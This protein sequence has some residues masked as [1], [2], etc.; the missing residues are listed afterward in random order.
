[1]L[2]VYEDN[3][4]LEEKIKGKRLPQ[5]KNI[6]VCCYQIVLQVFK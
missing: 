4:K 6:Q 3:K 5:V 2:D 1:M